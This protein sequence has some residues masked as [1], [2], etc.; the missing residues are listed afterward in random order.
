MNKPEL[1]FEMHGNQGPYL[2]MVHGI[3]SSRAQWIHNLA[4]LSTF[5]RPVVVELFGHGRSP[6]P[7]NPETYTPDNFVKEFEKIRKHLG[8]GKWFLCGQSLGASLTLRYALSHPES[9]KAQIFTNSRSALSDNPPEETMKMVAQ[10]LLEEGRGLLEHFP[11]NPVKSRHLPKEIKEALVRDI[12][13]IDIKGFG[14]MLIHMVTKCSV[15]R[16]VQKNIVP[17]LLIVGRFD[18]QFEPLVA[19]ARGNIPHMEMK[20]FDGGHAV[21]IDAAEL[22]NRAVKE[23][24]GRFQ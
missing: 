4:S 15:S 24:M 11:L 16:M 21:N 23:F 3:M 6:S 20:V 8:A 9:I 17:T 5:C 7:D 19:F 1:Y 2:L 22:F 18:K 13:H 10:R 14:Q 12:D